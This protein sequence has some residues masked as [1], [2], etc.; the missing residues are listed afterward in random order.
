ME[1]LTGS[2]YTKIMPA[3]FRLE[4]HH[5]LKEKMKSSFN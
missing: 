1:R 5:E 3:F 2:Q 4:E